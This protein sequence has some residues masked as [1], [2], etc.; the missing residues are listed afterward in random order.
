[1]RRCGLLL[2][3]LRILR[4]VSDMFFMEE[5]E[6]VVAISIIVP[7]VCR[8]LS[9]AGSPDYPSLCIIEINRRMIALYSEGIVNAKK[10]T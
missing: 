1:M 6:S 5:D 2:S 8:S 7:L 10:I 4:G 3:G 9:F